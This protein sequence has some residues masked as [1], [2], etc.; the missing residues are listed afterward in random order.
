MLFVLAAAW[1]IWSAV[2]HPGREDVVRT[3]EPEV[4]HVE[5]SE[6]GA[7]ETSETDGA[8]EA[9]STDGPD[10]VEP[11]QDGRPGGPTA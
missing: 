2:R 5:A 8:D 6:E 10:R 9:G 3:R 1:F 7:S 11:T 4:E